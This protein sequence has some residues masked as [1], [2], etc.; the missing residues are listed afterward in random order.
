MRANSWDKMHKKGGYLD[1]KF[2][3]EWL[4]K[5]NSIRVTIVNRDGYSDKPVI[6]IG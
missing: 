4:G 1:D 3:P 6:W 5:L 2:Q